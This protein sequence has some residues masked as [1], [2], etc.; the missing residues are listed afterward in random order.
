MYSRKILGRRRASSR[1]SATDAARLS[2]V[3]VLSA[4]TEQKARVND[5]NNRLRQSTRR[6][7]T[8][9]IAAMGARM[10]TARAL[11]LIATSIGASQDSDRK[12]STKDL[13]TVRR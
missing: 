1:N 4:Q 10:Q 11:E 13:H 6:G 7:S 9:V 8:H 12:S 5:A 3:I 2:D